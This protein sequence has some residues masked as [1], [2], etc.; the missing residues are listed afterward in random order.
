MTEAVDANSPIL[1]FV[2]LY[3]RKEHSTGPVYG[4]VL[5]TSACLLLVETCI[6]RAN[7]Q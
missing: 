6:G 3:Q 7:A 5:E 2:S 1:V 4:S